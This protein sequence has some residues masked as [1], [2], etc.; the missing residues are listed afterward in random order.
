MTKREEDGSIQDAPGEPGGL[1][2]QKK[3]Q[4]SARTVD[5]RKKESTVSD[6]RNLSKSQIK[7]ERTLMKENSLESLILAQDERWR[8]A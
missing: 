4:Q 7:D 3:E 6:Q 5:L 2:K 1:R 8:R